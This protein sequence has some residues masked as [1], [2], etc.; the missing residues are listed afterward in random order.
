[1]NTSK[2]HQTPKKP[3][4]GGVPVRRNPQHH[5]ELRRA[6]MQSRPHNSGCDEPY[7]YHGPNGLAGLILGLCYRRS[8][9]SFETC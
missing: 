4:S 7:E 8:F 1:M 9:E 5:M 3:Q 6:P 2:H